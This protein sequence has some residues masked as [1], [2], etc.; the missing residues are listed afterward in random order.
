[1]KK[2]ADH[3]AENLDKI[4]SCLLVFAIDFIGIMNC[5]FFR[6]IEF[7]NPNVTNKNLKVINIHSLKNNKYNHSNFPLPTSELRG[8]K[9]A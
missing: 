4:H 9:L 5:I 1:M 3:I 2:F 8:Q 6:D 7:S